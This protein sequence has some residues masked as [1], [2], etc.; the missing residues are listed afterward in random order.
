VGWGFTFFGQLKSRQ[1]Q[2]LEEGVSQVAP[3]D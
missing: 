1:A 2:A 3:A